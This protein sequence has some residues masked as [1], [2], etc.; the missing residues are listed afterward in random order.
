MSDSDIL[1]RDGWAEREALGEVAPSS[2]VMVEWT[3]LPVTLSTGLIDPSLSFGNDSK[4]VLSIDMNTGRVTLGEGV[5]LDEA[6]A[7]FWERVQEMFPGRP[8]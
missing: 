6:S 1:V 5:T 3:G 2:D 7:L 8:G 4:I